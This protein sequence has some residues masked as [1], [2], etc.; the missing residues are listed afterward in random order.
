MYT[1]LD[2]INVN[3]YSCIGTLMNSGKY[4]LFYNKKTLLSTL[5]MYTFYL[6]NNTI[7]P[8]SYVLRITP[9]VYSYEI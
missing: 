7:R 4:R 3:G 5:F 1:N 9:P 8:T 2:Y 6:I